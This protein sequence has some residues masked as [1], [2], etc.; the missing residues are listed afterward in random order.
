LASPDLAFK[1]GAPHFSF[2]PATTACRGLRHAF[3]G[4]GLRGP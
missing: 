3:V 1:P 2:F 4:I